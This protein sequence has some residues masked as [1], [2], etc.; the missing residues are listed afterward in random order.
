MYPESTTGSPARL[1]L[2]QTG[3]P[4]MIYRNLGK[5]GLRVSCLGL[6]TWVTFGGQITDEMAEQLMALAYD[7]GI[8]LFDTAEVYAAGKAEVVL[9]NIIKKKGWRTFAASQ[10]LWSSLFPSLRGC[11]WDRSGRAILRVSGPKSVNHP[12]SSGRD[13]SH[14]PGKWSPPAT[15]E[16]SPGVME[17][18]GRRSGAIHPSLPGAYGPFPGQGPHLPWDQLG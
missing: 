6:G 13:M 7:N 15:G 11:V 10:P 4:G 8:N 9:G 14:S 16:R 1:S 5:S 18:K 3:S 12:P 17:P 2:R